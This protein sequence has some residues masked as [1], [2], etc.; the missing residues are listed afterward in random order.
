MNSLPENDI[1]LGGLDAFM[2][3][4]K[5]HKDLLSR[6]DEVVERAV[7]NQ[8]LGIIDT[9]IDGLLSI[10]QMSGIG[11]AK[12]LYVTKFQ[13]DNFNRRDTWLDWAIERTGK[14]KVTVT[15][16]FRVWEMLVSGDVPREYAKKLETMPIRC[17]IPIA[18]LW[19][20]KFEITS[21][22]W[23]KLANAPDPSTVNKIIR[24][25]KG[26]EP[27]ENSL[28]IEWDVEAKS[29]TG[30]K[31]GKPHV[32]YLQYDE[33]DEVVTAMLSRLLSDKTLEK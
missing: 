13:W 18:T 26:V 17:L 21:Q 28:Q 16:Y 6:I 14:V 30:W 29:V 2:P 15:R 23:N 8:D 27:K 31:N 4:A 25:I 33:N 9:A 20:Q 1:V 22:Q 3:V 12:F 10:S 5:I 24:E 32:I 11:L 7:A 19:S